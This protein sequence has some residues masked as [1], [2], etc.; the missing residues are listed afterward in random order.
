[1]TVVKHFVM[2]HLKDIAITETDLEG[3]N[4][5][6]ELIKSFVLCSD[7]SYENG[8]ATGD[9]T[10]IALI[11]LGNQYNMTKDHLTQKHKRVGEKPFDSDRKLMSTLNK[12]GNRYR[13]HTKGAIDNILQI[14]THAL[15]EGKVVPLTEQLKQEYLKVASAMSNK[16]LRV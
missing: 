7:A 9:P 13:V 3:S 12:E 8:K 14:S 16:A 11:V 5:E 15:V 4:D 6:K 1:M 10:E 2:N